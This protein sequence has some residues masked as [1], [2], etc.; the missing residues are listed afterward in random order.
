MTEPSDAALRGAIRTEADRIHESAVNSAQGQLEAGK[1]WRALHWGLGAL[2]AALSAAA[3]VITFASSV[4]VLSG[5]LA[6]LSAI[7]V[8][9][10]TGARPDKLSEQAHN[11]G[12]GYVS[13]RNDARRLRDVSVR[14]DPLPELRDAVEDLSRRASGLNHAA[15]AIPRW[16]YLLSKRNIEKDGG[17]RFEADKA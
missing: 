15:D 17:Q 9:L 7:T 6:I 8:T 11:V 2:T 4:Q 14:V 16:A 5:I 10:L 3:A 13:L 12:N 1:G